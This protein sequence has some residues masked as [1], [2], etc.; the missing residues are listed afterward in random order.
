MSF[1]QELRLSTN[2]ARTFSGFGDQW[3]NHIDVGL[4][5]TIGNVLE[6]RLL[7]GVT[8]TNQA[9]FSQSALMDTPNLAIADEYYENYPFSLSTSVFDRGHIKLNPKTNYTTIFDF[10]LLAGK[11][12][13]F[14]D[15]STMYLGIGYLARF[16]NYTYITEISP[17]FVSNTPTGEPM[18]VTFAMPLIQSFILF[19]PLAQISYTYSIS[20]RLALGPSFSVSLGGLRTSNIGFTISV[21][22][23]K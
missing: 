1:G 9:G 2:V 12:F 18:Q 4:G 19:E 15:H 13:N 10:G 5:Y 17:W 8:F 6:V 20:K 14:G 22:A 11:Y 23:S 7:T 3:G 16:V 21:L